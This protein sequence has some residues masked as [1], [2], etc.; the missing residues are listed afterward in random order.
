MWD[1]QRNPWTCLQPDMAHPTQEMDN[2]RTICYGHNR[3]IGSQIL[4]EVQVASDLRP[5]SISLDIQTW[6]IVTYPDQIHTDSHFSS[7]QF[8]PQ[9]RIASEGIHSDVPRI[10]KSSLPLRG[11][12]RNR[13]PWACILRLLANSSSAVNNPKPDRLLTGWLA[14]YLRWFVRYTWCHWCGYTTS[15]SVIPDHPLLTKENLT[16]IKIHDQAL[17]A[18]ERNT[19]SKAS[20]KH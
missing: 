11:E 12:F 9:F 13:F 2:F 6:N 14:A 7:I 1:M 3:I 19:G 4:P 10:T 20:I 5:T 17:E 8:L 15:S 16:V 18:H